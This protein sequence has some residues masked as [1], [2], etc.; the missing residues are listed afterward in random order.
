MHVKKVGAARK[1]WRR[2]QYKRWSR[3]RYL[4]L[5]Y[6]GW[7]GAIASAVSVFSVLDNVFHLQ[8][9]KLLEGFLEL[10]REI[11][12]IPLN[13]IWSVFS[14]RAPLW[15]NDVLALWFISGSVAFRTYAFARKFATDRLAIEH[16]IRMGVDTE[17]NVHI[18]SNSAEPTLI[19]APALVFYPIYAFLCFGLTPLAIARL[20]Y[21]KPIP[22]AL[23]NRMSNAPTPV[24]ARL[25]SMFVQ[26][27][28]AMALGI[29]IFFSLN[30]GLSSVGG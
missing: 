2:L 28:R 16:N 29:V 10:Y 26:H 8:F 19:T 24:A 6:V 20:F 17:E 22:I 25:T 14:F 5:G 3:E 18:L 11:W 7:L 15:F 13:R 21:L 23:M 1:L 9:A 30:G 4:D 27:I 12:H